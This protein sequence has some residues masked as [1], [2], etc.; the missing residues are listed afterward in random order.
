M[1]AAERVVGS[2]RFQVEEFVPDRIR[3]DIEPGIAAATA[4]D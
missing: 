3:V 2:Y 4:G 1:L